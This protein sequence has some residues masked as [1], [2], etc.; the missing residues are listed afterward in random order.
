MVS[1]Q[2]LDAAG[3]LLRVLL[4]YRERYFSAQQHSSPRGEAHILETNQH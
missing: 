1:V 4:L 2:R 3:H